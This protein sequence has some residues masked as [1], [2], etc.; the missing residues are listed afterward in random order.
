MRDKEAKA[1]P[2]CDDKAAATMAAS[3]VAGYFKDNDWK[4]I[5]FF[6]NSSCPHRAA[7]VLD[8]CKKARCKSKK[9]K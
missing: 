9:L 1:A 3:S 8:C 7:K 2:K 4:I 5:S 6:P